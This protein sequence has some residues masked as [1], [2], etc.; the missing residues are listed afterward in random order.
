MSTPA[1][2]SAD[3]QAMCPYW[4]RVDAILG[5]RDD[6]V[7]AGQKLLPK[8]ANETDDDYK[9]R[10]K[11][12]KFTNIFRDIVENL[13]A[14][15]FAQELTVETTNAQ[16]KDLCS[17][18]DGQG[19]SI[20]VFGA[21][22]FFQGIAMGLDWILVDKP[23]IKAGATIAE[24]RA[25]G[26][27]PYWVHICADDVIAAKSV[28]FG[29]QEVL[30]HVRIEE[31]AVVKVDEWT[32]KE[33]ERIRV[34][35][36]DVTYEGNRV[37]AVAPATFEVYEKQIDPVTK[38]VAWV[39]VDAGP[40]GIGIIPMVPYFVGRRE[41]ATYQVLP[42]M[43]DAAD[44][45]VEHYQAE[46]DLKYASKF[47]TMPI[48]VGEGVSPP[49][50]T[51][52]FIT[53][54]GTGTREIPEPIRVGPKTVLFSPTDAN[55]NHGSWKWM[56]ISAQSLTFLAKQVD[57]IEMQLREL[58]RQPLT[59]QSGNLTVITT[60][61]AASKGNSAVQAWALNLKDALEYALRI[62][63]MWLGTTSNATV[64]I[65]TDFG[66][67]M[68]SDKAPD[69]LLKL[70]EKNE[71]SRKALIREAKR[72]DFLSPDYDEA[73]DMTEILAEIGG[74]DTTTDQINALPGGQ[75]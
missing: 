57:H 47:S 52:A 19:N 14:R 66:L 41:G 33:V 17:D 42:A 45:Q 25:I 1:D 9:D 53:E 27:R 11:N 34:F 50:R 18:I 31:E 6:V 75:Q 22:T 44:L 71:I 59:A 49:T 74:G 72:R 13:A 51:E 21:E 8:F 54:N 28:M 10:L 39:S 3:H 4:E 7:E 5:G 46:T 73:A 23:P 40:V 60:A 70:R 38:R 24:E 67:E 37:I 68:E 48:L 30:T 16:L 12:A 26:A 2:K 62:T 43:Q 35:N 29:G 36:R 32:D 55:G 15:P 64:Q 20:H 58:G 65:F 56:E 69:F 63:D 61:M